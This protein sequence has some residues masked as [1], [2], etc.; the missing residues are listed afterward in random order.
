MLLT[1]QSFRIR[2]RLAREFWTLRSKPGDNVRD[3]LCRHGSSGHVVAPVRGAQFRPSSDHRCAKSLIAY[4]SQVCPIHD[5]TG[6]LA[7]CAVRTMAGGTES[8]KHIR[9][10]TW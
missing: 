4:K 6:F 3:F 10:A 7:A 5:G 2:V 8:C 1:L 9:A